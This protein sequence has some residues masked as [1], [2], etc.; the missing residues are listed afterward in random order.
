MLEDSLY[1]LSLFM[2]VASSI[3]LGYQ[4]GLRSNKKDSQS[5]DAEP[6]LEQIPDTTEAE[7][8]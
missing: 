1:Y 5:R 2:V 4:L 8:E 6:T 3:Y 7:H